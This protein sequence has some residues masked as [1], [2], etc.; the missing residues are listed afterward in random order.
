MKTA[1]LVSFPLH[2]YDNHTKPELLNFVLQL[3]CYEFPANPTQKHIYT[4]WSVL[5]LFVEIF[6]EILKQIT[7]KLF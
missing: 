3:F 7:T 2:S 4:Y 6:E 1:D 5:P